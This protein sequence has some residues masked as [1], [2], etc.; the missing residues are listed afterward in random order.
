MK[1]LKEKLSAKLSKNGGFT[2]VEML[3]VIAI[4][5]VLVAITI[6]LVTTELENAREAT[7]AANLRSAYA[8]VM[9]DAVQNGG[10]T[11][12]TVEVPLTQTQDGWQNTNIKN[13]GGIAM[14]DSIAVSGATIVAS[15]AGSD[16]QFAVKS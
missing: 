16:V 15:F 12:K 4:I 6:P 2:L 9:I 5:A 11:T 8:V 10:S 13:I 14:N 7:D 3:I 1:K